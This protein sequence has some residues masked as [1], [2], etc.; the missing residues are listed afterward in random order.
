MCVSWD[1]LNAKKM[2]PA[3]PFYRHKEGQSTCTRRSEVVAF[4]PN[5]GVQWMI[6][7][8]SALWGTGE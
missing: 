5:R 4:S 3:S 6:T 7:V 1:E 2:E 8:G